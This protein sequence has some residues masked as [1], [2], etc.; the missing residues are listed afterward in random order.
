MTE[1]ND[2][3]VTLHLRVKDNPRK[4]TQ[5][6]R[7]SFW[8]INNKLKKLKSGDISVFRDLDINPE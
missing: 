4:I 6:A 8:F 7:N 3:N 5:N 1:L 2:Y